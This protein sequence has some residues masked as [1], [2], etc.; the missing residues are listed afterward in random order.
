M[1]LIMLKW[2]NARTF[3]A[4]RSTIVYKVSRITTL[5]WSEAVNKTMKYSK[6]IKKLSYISYGRCAMASCS[7]PF[8]ISD[9]MCSSSLII[10]SK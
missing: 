3:W 5:T 7:S 4:A 2:M 9:A 1:L 10:S 6:L 8:L